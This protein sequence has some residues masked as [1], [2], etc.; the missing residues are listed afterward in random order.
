M[1]KLS[2]AQVYVLRALR[3]DLARVVANPVRQDTVRDLAMRGLAKRVGNG[4]LYAMWITDAGR[5]ALSE[6]EREAAK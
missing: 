5:A 2:A 6:A 3:D 4:T 1:A